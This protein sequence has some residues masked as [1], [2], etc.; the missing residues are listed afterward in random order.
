MSNFIWTLMSFLW[1]R[2]VTFLAKLWNKFIRDIALKNA[3]S[4]GSS[5]SAGAISRDPK[6]IQVKRVGYQLVNGS[7]SAGRDNFQEPLT[8]LEL[9]DTAIRTDSYVMQTMMKYSELL[10][11]SGYYFE[12]K[13]E[14]A[15]QYLRTRFEVM[16]VATGVPTEE[17]FQGIGEDIVRYSNAFLVKAR[18]KGGVG[19]PPGMSL[20]PIPPAREPIA[21]YFR[22]P[23]HTISIARD[24][25]GNVLQY[26]QEVE[27]GGDPI[28]FRPED[29]VHISVNRPVGRPF[30]EPWIAPVLEDV[31]LLRK[32]E[33]NAALLLYRH[34]FPLLSYTVGIDKPGYEATDEELEEVQSVIEN[35]PSD[36]AI[37]LPERHK[38]EAINLNAIDGKPYLDYFEQRVFTGL[39]VSAVDMGRGDTANRNTADAMTGIKADRVKGWQRSLQAQIDKFI[40]DELLA[41]GGFDPLVNPEF[42]VDFVFEEI[43]QERKI[44]KENHVLQKWNSHL[45]TFEE[46]RLE[47]GL[48]PVVDESRLRYQM[49]DAY[50]DEAK[51]TSDEV[52]N[53]N[54]PENQHGKRTSPKRKTESLVESE[55]VF[56]HMAISH[57]EKLHNALLSQYRSLEK[58]A[59]DMVEA[60][61]NKQAFP[62]KEPEE[63]LSAMHFSKDRMLRS[64]QEHTKYA[65]SEGIEKAKKD[66]GRNSYPEVNVGSA[67]GVVK[68]YAHDSLENL[69]KNLKL[70][71]SRRMEEAQSKEEVLLA[72]KGVFS[73]LEHRMKFMSKTIMARAF[74]YGYVLAAMSYDEEFVKPL[75]EGQCFTC[76]Q[77]AKEP[78]SLKQ[79]LSLDEVAIFYRIPPWHP[80][81][82]CLLTLEGGEE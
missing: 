58:D 75:Y 69:E 28:I 72:V 65:L 38:I 30:G 6:A 22:L 63:W 80:N 56:D 41:E 9:I 39:G 47:L 1:R 10:F 59:I 67:L 43:E 42:N 74:N 81:C 31:R 62:V 34:I 71:I 53:K 7:R 45:T 32:V 73:A 8:D 70:S 52:D 49:V 3:P 25:K 18:A 66:C 61:I 76:S 15:L 20:I 77:K 14:Q 35:M 36:G 46:A 12:G 44:A 5:R 64:V 16:S 13:N 57:F 68:E 33:E 21:G 48:D 26:R 55:T 24:E 37:V 78:I 17:L 50:T 29:I 51:D 27:G 40:I 4:G 60:H 23:P 11:K 54:A 82:E 79:F 2:G 19:L